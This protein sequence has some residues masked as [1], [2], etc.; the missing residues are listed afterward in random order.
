[1]LPLSLGRLERNCRWIHFII[2][3][4]VVHNVGRKKSWRIPPPEAKQ[5]T[6]NIDKCSNDRIYAGPWKKDY[7]EPSEVKRVYPASVLFSATISWKLKNQPQNSSSQ[8]ST[9][10][11]SVG[12]WSA[13]ECWHWP[14]TLTR[15]GTWQNWMYCMVVP[16]SY[17]ADFPLVSIPWFPSSLRRS[18]PNS[19][20][21]K[22]N[23][24]Y[25]SRENRIINMVV[26]RGADTSPYF[27]LLLI[28]NK[29]IH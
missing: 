22:R 9:P 18:K 1:M 24:S 5:S 26:W 6:Y 29:Y 13:V 23:N 8:Y 20:T 15:I 12:N 2:G 4:K 16:S 28:H 17:L 7:M 11:Y 21:K 25:Y 14:G 19:F 27:L 10:Y 3:H